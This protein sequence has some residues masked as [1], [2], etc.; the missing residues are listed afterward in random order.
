MRKIKY[1]LQNNIHMVWLSVR[2]AQNLVNT[3]L[4][5]QLGKEDI[6]IV[7]QWGKQ[8]GDPSDAVVIE[9]NNFNNIDQ[10]ADFVNNIIIE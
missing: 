6:P 5:V 10:F 8:M 2:N 7:M 9:A 1:F 3:N 4:L